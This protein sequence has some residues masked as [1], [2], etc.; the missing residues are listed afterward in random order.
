[1]RDD[2]QEV[3]YVVVVRGVRGASERRVRGGGDA[4]YCVWREYA[5]EEEEGVDGGGGVTGRSGVEGRSWSS[6]QLAAA[7]IAEATNPGCSSA[8]RVRRISLSGCWVLGT[9][10]ASVG[11]SVGVVGLGAAGLRPDFLGCVPAGVAF[12]LAGVGELGG[13]IEAIT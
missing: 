8:E 5:V 7:A 13:P 10:T 6:S 4:V 3:L 1:M 11:E 9:L 12:R 2:E